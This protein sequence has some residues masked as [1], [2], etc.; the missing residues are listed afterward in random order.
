MIST[1][2]RVKNH[3]F[4]FR[5]KHGAIHTAILSCEIITLNGEECLLS[6]SNDITERKEAESKLVVANTTLQKL[7]DLDGLTQIA[8]RR[9]FDAYLKYHLEQ[10][11]KQQK[12]L[13]MILCDVDHFKHYNDYY[14]HLQGDTCLIRLA[15]IF[16]RMLT[17]H[18]DFVARYGGEE[19]AMILPGRSPTKA[20]QVVQGILEAV[21]ASTIP[22]ARSS[23]APFVTVS[24][25]GYV[26]TPDNLETVA[27]PSDLIGKADEALYRAKQQG[28]N[29]IVFGD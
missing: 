29:Q 8:N 23:T 18:T 9:R 24:F 28:R 25:G 14:G 12:Y 13:A 16:R 27:T 20:Y 6:L 4:E 3:E 17:T 1:Q 10:S 2:R 7:A 21:R 11:Q 19:F 15:K 5:T 26:L 22:H